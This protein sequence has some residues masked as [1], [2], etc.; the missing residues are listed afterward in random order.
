M[1]GSEPVFTSKGIIGIP[2]E[3]REINKM[4]RLETDRGF[5]AVPS[6]N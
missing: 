6:Y 2:V 5:M 1:N 4:Y 3:K